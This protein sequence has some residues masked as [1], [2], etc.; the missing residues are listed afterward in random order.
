MGH[1]AVAIVEK[2]GSEVKNLNWRQVAIT[3]Y[4]NMEKHG[5]SNVWRKWLTAVTIM[6]QIRNRLGW[7]LLSMYISKMQI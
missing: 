1:E 4:I 6:R 3:S 5:S 7:V 2:V